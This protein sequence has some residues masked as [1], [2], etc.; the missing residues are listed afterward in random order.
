MFAICFNVFACCVHVAAITIFIIRDASWPYYI[1]PLVLL[2]LNA[3]CVV[4]LRK[5]KSNE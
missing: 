5:T 1:A 3:S 4:V 2:P